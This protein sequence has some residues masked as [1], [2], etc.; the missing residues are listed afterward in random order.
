MGERPNSLEAAACTVVPEIS[1]VLAGLRG[2]AG[3][4]IACL[5]GAGPTCF[6]IFAEAGAADA[7]ARSLK[8][9]QPGWWVEAV[10]LE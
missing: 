7:A 2:H 3:V 10:R 8:A 4:E 5:S 9:A 6:G 1:A